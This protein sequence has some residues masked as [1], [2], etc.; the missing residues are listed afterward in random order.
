MNLGGGHPQPR[1]EVAAWTCKH[2][3]DHPVEGDSPKQTRGPGEQAPV[4]RG[5]AGESHPRR[6]KGRWSGRRYGQKAWSERASDIVME[7]SWVGPPC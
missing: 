1:E 2:G 6:P 5:R 3:S 4:V 7:L